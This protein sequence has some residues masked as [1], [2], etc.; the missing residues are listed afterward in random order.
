MKRWFTA[1]AMSV[2]IAVLVAMVATK[3]FPDRFDQGIAAYGAGNY[4]RALEH[5]TPS[6]EAGDSRAQLL[7]GIIYEHGQ[8]VPPDFRQAVAWYRKAADQGNAEAQALVGIMYAQVRG[9]VQDD[10]QA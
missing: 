7:L 1:A 9:V 8:G 4:A 10:E 3:S 5:L 2:A 6:A